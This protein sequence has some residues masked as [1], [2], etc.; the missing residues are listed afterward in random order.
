[1]RNPVIYLF[2]PIDSCADPFTDWRVLVGSEL[3]K[4]ATVFCPVGAWY[5]ECPGQ[6]VVEI[7]ELIVDRASL[8]IGCWMPG[9][10]GCCREVERAIA[11]GKKVLAVVPDLVSCRSPYFNDERIRFCTDFMEAVALA[12]TIITD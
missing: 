3:S 12:K 10:V 6:E 11:Q 7:N 5:T 2:G 4:V 9:S 1:M 8:L